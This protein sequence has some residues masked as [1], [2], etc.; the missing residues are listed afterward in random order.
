MQIDK[1]IRLHIRLQEPEFSAVT[2]LIL[3]IECEFRRKKSENF[4]WLIR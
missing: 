1:H 4:V 2:L 3:P